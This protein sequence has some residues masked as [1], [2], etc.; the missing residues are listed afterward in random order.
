[1][2]LARVSRT[3][4][5][6]RLVNFFRVDVGEAKENIQEIV[7]ADLPGY[8]YASGPKSE[9]REWQQMIE[10]YLE[11]RPQAL[12]VLVDGELGAQPTDIEMVR[13]AESLGR[14]VI[15]VATKLDKL[16]RS[17]RKQQTDRIAGQLAVP[18]VIGFSAKE[19]FGVEELWRA[20]LSSV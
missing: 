13:W 4:G 16:S 14:K 11:T 2:A 19:R 6:T 1:K 8:G 15:A 5:R 20:C 18:E 7:L 10:Q 9:T 12:V 17:R 3:P